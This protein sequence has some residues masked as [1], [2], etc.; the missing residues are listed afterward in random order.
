MILNEHNMLPEEARHCHIN[1]IVQN[2]K[3]KII[4]PKKFINIKII[5]DCWGGSNF[6][7][8]AIVISN[9]SERVWGFF[10]L[11]AIHSSVSLLAATF[12]GASP[13]YI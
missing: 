4:S 2:E 10:P 13:N 3:G 9:L 1:T 11:L 7:R 12:L 8:F 6:P 5:I